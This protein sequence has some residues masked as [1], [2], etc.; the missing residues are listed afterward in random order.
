M[1]FSADATVIASCSNDKTVRLW[2][3]ETG[4]CKGTLKV[5]GSP[6]STLSDQEA[7]C[8][9]NR[10]P[11]LQRAFGTTNIRA[12]KTHWVQFGKKEERDWSS[13]VLDIAYA[14]SGDTLAVVGCYDG[15][16][17][18]VDAAT[19][20]VKR[21][22]TVDSGKDGVESISY[23]PAGDMI[24]AGCWDGKIHIL[25]TVTVAVKRSLTVDSGLYGVR[26][27]SYSPAGDMIAAG[28]WN[29]KI[30]LLDTATFAVKRSLTGHSH[31]CTCTFDEDGDLE[32]AGPTCPLT[33]HS[34]W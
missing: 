4:S 26:S 8:Y 25:D 2:D 22:L 17:L 16:V 19:V 29:G 10:Y 13:E 27:I 33:G 5:E 20:V 14:P 31:S 11:D 21:S 7:Q 32:E 9:L 15:N 6:P 30:H 18:L 23:S 24:A 1:A 3:V 12:A 28:C 34:D